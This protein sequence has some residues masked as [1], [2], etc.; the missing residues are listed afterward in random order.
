MDRQL[1]SDFED[2]ASEGLNKLNEFYPGMKEN[3]FVGYL[4][5]KPGE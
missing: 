3:Y 4:K 1:I 5:E 2:R